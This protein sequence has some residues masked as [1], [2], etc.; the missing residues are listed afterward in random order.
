M[1]ELAKSSL[2]HVRQLV[3]FH[4]FYSIAIF[5]FY[6]YNVLFQYDGINLLMFLH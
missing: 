5:L 4:T 2:L 1:I 6:A 3:V